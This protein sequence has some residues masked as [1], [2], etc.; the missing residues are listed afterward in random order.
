MEDKP[1]KFIQISDIHL[2]EHQDGALLGVKTHDSF[3]AVLEMIKKN[4]NNQDLI[5]MSGDIT[6]DA[7]E[8]AYRKAADYLSLFNV[9]IYCVPGNHD[10]I[11]VIASVYPY[12]NVLTSRCIVDKY[13]QIILL[14]S[15]MQRKVEGHLA[16]D[17]LDFLRQKL[18]SNPNHHALIMFHHQPVPVGSA[19]LDQLGVTNANEL[20]ELLSEYPQ[21]KVILFG[22]VHQIHEGHKNGISYY[23]LPSCCIQF[24]PGVKDFALDPIPPGYRWVELYKD[25]QIKTGIQRLDRYIGTFDDNA[26]GY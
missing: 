6:Q 15:H 5:I 9:P 2:F 1:L 22:H 19:W 12:K 13:W 25:G 26:K 20:W 21:A 11:D 3:L 7:S 4:S 17:Q 23:S 16:K 8:A 24:K 10:D 14:D 18:E